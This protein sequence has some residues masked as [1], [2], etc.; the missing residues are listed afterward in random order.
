MSE[1]QQLE[2]IDTGHAR[3]GRVSAAPGPLASFARF[4][5]CGGG[6][7][8]VASA[9]VPTV[10]SVMPWVVA[11]ALITVVS[12]LLCTELHSLITFRTG[13]RA[14]LRRHLQ[15]AG[16][17]AASYGVTTVAVLLLHA[18]QPTTGRLMEQ[19]VYLSAAG[20]AG[21][22]RFLVLRLLVFADRRARTEPTVNDVTAEGNWGELVGLPANGGQRPV[23]VRGVRNPAVDSVRTRPVCRRRAEVS[24]PA[25][26]RPRLERVRERAHR[27]VPA[28]TRHL[29][30]RL[31]SG[32]GPAM[33]SKGAPVSAGTAVPV[34]PF[35]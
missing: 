2:A 3:T 6:V 16:S 14:G 18:A 8:L 11:N 28:Q 29:P 35:H 24:P 34:A 25:L 7:G 20:L 4:V 13:R 9:V 17:A 5:V 33:A 31:P 30:R 10:A 22:G 32:R 15:S 12:T 26:R 19:A 21:I 23:A 1:S 27:P